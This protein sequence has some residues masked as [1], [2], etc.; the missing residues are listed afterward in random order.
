MAEIDRIYTERPYY[1]A[2]RITKQLNRD[3]KWRN[4][5]RKR[6]RRL[7]R[8]MGIEAIYPKPRLSRPNKEHC[9][10]PYLLK[11]LS[12]ER[13]NQVWSSDITYIPTKKGKVDPFV[14]T[15]NQQSLSFII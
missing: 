2:R 1:G 6:V 12:I 10:Y 8:Q 9:K 7:M 5:D 13:P 11:G 3:F 15:K 14:K 4:V